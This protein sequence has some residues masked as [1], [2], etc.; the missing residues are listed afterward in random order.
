MLHS[1]THKHYVK[2][3]NVLNN[4]R[5]LEKVYVM[6]MVIVSSQAKTTKQNEFVEK[7]EENKHANVSQVV[8]VE[9]ASHG[10]NVSAKRVSNGMEKLA[11]NYKQKKIVQQNNVLMEHTA[12]IK[13][14]QKKK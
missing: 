4:Q 6:L 10:D 13:N 8:K 2:V 7:G 3:K 12:K 9:P 11:N 5:I 1:M 14:P